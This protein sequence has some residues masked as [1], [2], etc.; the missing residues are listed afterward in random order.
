MFTYRSSQKESCCGEW[1]LNVNLVVCELFSF[2]C[3]QSVLF[4]CFNKKVFFLDSTLF[5]YLRRF[6][7][8][9]LY[10]W[11]IFNT[12]QVISHIHYR[13]WLT[14]I[15]L[16]LFVICVMQSVSMM[17]NQTYL[18]KNLN[19][20]YVMK[21]SLLMVIENPWWVFFDYSRSNCVNEWLLTDA[22]MLQEVYMQY[23]CEEDD[24][25]WTRNEKKEGTICEW[26]R[27]TMEENSC[28]I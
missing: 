9:D 5:V 21:I 15:F 13:I 28:I 25:S 6:H 16:T 27:E 4:C 14:T 10:R 19:A 23:V 12:L 17:L 3:I 8:P 11:T 26:L 24:C 18:P 20:S 2:I 22:Y 7:I 1:Y